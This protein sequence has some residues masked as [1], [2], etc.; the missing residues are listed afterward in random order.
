MQRLER[1]NRGDEEAP[2]RLERVGLL[3]PLARL[4]LELEAGEQLPEALARAPAVGVE[5]RRLLDERLPE[6]VELLV[7]RPRRQPESSSRPAD[8]A[9]LAPDGLGVRSEDDAERG[10]DDVERGGFERS[11]EGR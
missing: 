3:D 11:S 2:Q 5:R 4:D 7:G 6:R 9:E 10:R 1:R 8:A